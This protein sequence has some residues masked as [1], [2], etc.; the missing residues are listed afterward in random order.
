MLGV[1]SPPQNLTELTNQPAV[2]PNVQVK[3]G[4]VLVSRAPRN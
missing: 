4:L 2:A 1:L 3:S